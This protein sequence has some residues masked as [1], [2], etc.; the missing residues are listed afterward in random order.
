MFLQKAGVSPRFS[1]LLLDEGEC[2][3]GDYPGTHRFGDRDPTEGKLRICSHSIIFDPDDVR[4]PIVRIKYEKIEGLDATRERID[5]G[6]I[7]AADVGDS[8]DPTFVN[9]DD[10]EVQAEPIPEDDTPVALDDDE[11][12]DASND[13]SLLEAANDDLDEEEED[14]PDEAQFEI[15]R[16]LLQS[17]PKVQRQ[18]FYSQVLG[19]RVTAPHAPFQLVALLCILTT[20]T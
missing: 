12:T 11:G 14:L 15:Q 8:S 10:D 5:D 16:E 9:T 7:G 4:L 17:M 13:T 20:A 1:L 6:D 19:V 2:Y 3:L 18:R